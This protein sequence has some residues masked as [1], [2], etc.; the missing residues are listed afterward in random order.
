MNK[1]DIRKR[2]DENNKIIMSLFT[3]NQ[4]VLNNT[5]AKLLAENEQLQNSCNHEYE[6]GFCI[7]CDKEDPNNE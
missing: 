7:Y 4:F 5:V 3:P 2:I 6:D 1:L